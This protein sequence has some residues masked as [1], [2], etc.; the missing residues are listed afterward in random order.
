MIVDKAGKIDTQHNRL[1][2]FQQLMYIHCFEGWRRGSVGFCLNF[3]NIMQSLSLEIYFQMKNQHFGFLVRFKSW[4]DSITLRLITF[5]LSESS[6]LPAVV[7]EQFHILVREP[8]SSLPLPL[9][10]FIEE[11]LKTKLI[12]LNFLVLTD[13]PPSQM[14]FLD[15][16]LKESR[17][18]TPGREPMPQ[19][20]QVGQFSFF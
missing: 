6:S 7:F 11:E 20:H 19:L 3:L 4:Y 14:S 18:S 2:C 13:R 5:I 12:F 8:L 1:Y 17:H 15:Q 10:A 16:F 9:I